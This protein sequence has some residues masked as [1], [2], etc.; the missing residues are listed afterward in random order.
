MLS[1][2]RLATG[3]VQGTKQLMFPVHPIFWEV[4]FD[5]NWNVKQPSGLT[6]WMING[7]PAPIL[8]QSS[9]VTIPVL[10]FAC[11]TLNTSVHAPAAP[12]VSNW[13]NS[14]WI[15]APGFV[16]KSGQNVMV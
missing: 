16:T 1:S 7:T 3:F 12:S 13:V 10:L 11:Q 5:V 14:I 8:P 9:E 4:L 6:D 15:T 2:T